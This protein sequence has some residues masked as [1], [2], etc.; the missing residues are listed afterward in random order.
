MQRFTRRR[1]DILKSCHCFIFWTR[2]GWSNHTQFYNQGCKKCGIPICP[3]C[4]IQSHFK[5]KDT[6]IITVCKKARTKI[7]N[8]LTDMQNKERDVDNYLHKGVGY[9][10]TCSRS[11]SFK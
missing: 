10:D 4:E 9:T 11:Q 2:N 7:Q 6:D 1:P 3:E 5:H 8:G